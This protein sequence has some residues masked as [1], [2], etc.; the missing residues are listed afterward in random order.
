MR[1]AGRS[2]GAPLVGRIVAG[3]ID[4]TTRVA[5][6]VRVNRPLALSQRRSDGS[7]TEDL[8]GR[9]RQRPTKAGRGLWAADDRPVRRHRLTGR[10]F[11]MD[12][13]NGTGQRV[14]LHVEHRQ[15]GRGGSLA[16][17]LKRDLA[18]GDRARGIG[19]P[20]GFRITPLRQGSKRWQTGKDT[21]RDMH[22]SETGSRPPAERVGHAAV[23]QPQRQAARRRS[24]ASPAR[25]ASSISA[26]AGSGI[27]ASTLPAMT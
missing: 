13:R 27:A 18:F 20:D 15:V 1:R 2:G 17:P 11:G 3:K 23:T 19:K 21:C 25:P 7:A 16:M 8:T 10:P 14:R 22:L 12:D 6:V 24:A 5:D 9:A 26:E 4:H